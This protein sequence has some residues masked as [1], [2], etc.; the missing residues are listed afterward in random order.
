MSAANH[1]TGF[2]ASSL[3]LL[4]W[5]FPLL[6]DCPFLLLDDGFF[7]L[8]FF[9]V[10]FSFDPVFSFF[11][12]DVFLISISPLFFYNPSSFWIAFSPSVLGMYFFGDGK[13]RTCLLDLAI[14]SLLIVICVTCVISFLIFNFIFFSLIISLPLFL[15]PCVLWKKEELSVPIVVFEIFR[16]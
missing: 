7:L 1:P 13:V 9:S 3:L 16:G 15:F 11:F 5:R 6:L 14:N 4:P 8:L 12:S 2:N 10:L